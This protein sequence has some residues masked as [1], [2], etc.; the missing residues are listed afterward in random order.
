MST[1]PFR[2]KQEVEAAI[3]A[4]R[5]HL[6]RGGL[7]GHPTETVYGVGCR[8]ES[9]GLR[10]LSRLK[11][12]SAQKPF[13]VLVSDNTMA[14]EWGFVFSDAARALARAFWPGP[15]TLVLEVGSGKL[16]NSL[17]GERGGV[18]IRWTSHSG[19]ARLIEAMNFPIT[20]TS[21]NPAGAEPALTAAEVVAHLASSLESEHLLVLDGGPLRAS[22][23]ST[24][25]D[26]TGHTP[27]LLR[28]GAVPAEQLYA[29]V[30]RIER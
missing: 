6:E 10:R 11:G 20:S 14:D 22:L 26:C 9:A 5:S 17:R 7:L 21:A 29:Q 1:I 3:P 8:P 24:V 23:P 4:V 30:G 25:I 15:L 19:V 27:L 2:S 13:L 18:A 12:R 28:E 16:P